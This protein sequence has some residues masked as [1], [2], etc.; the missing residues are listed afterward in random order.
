MLSRRWKGPVLMSEIT[1]VSKAVQAV[2][3]LAKEGI[4]VGK[5]TG[6]IQKSAIEKAEEVQ[7]IVSAAGAAVSLV[8]LAS[9]FFGLKYPVVD[10]WPA[11]IHDQAGV[12][13]WD[14]G[15]YH[16]VYFRSLDGKLEQSFFSG[17]HGAAK[18]RFAALVAE[19]GVGD[20]SEMPSGN[21]EKLLTS[22]DDAPLD[23]PG[24]PMKHCRVCGDRIKKGLKYQTTRRFVCKG[25]GHRTHVSCAA[26]VGRLCKACV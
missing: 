10:S 14:R 23:S 26:E 15:F 12:I 5:N 9:D 4:E 21:E 8:A 18:K 1:A 25:C 6:V 19:F 24:E 17:G 11:V 22:G 20:R 2:A 7:A 3:E 13:I 16:E